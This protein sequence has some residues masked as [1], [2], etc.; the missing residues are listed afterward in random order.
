MLVGDRS[1]EDLTSAY[2]SIYNWKFLFTPLA[3]LGY[4]FEQC[5]FRSEISNKLSE[6]PKSKT[7]VSWFTTPNEDI[8]VAISTKYNLNSLKEYLETRFDFHTLDVAIDD[9]GSYVILLLKK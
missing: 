9:T 1:D 6:V 3:D 7:I 2:D 5:T 4:E 8:Q